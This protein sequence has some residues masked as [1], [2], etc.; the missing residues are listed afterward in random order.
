M[1]TVFALPPPRL[2]KK[3]FAI[4]LFSDNGHN[5]TMLEKI[6]R[7]YT[8][9]DISKTKDKNGKKKTQSKEKNSCPDNLFDVLPF[10][11]TDL[12]EE[13]NKPYIVIALPPGRNIPQNEKKL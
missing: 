12:S 2:K 1:P 7:E 8:P 13:E 11:E 6:A 10:R 3:E 4:N 9:P 5:R